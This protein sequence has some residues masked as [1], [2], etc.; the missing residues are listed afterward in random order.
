MEYPSQEEDF[1]NI[2]PLR[3]PQNIPLNLKKKLTKPFQHY[4]IHLS[5]FLNELGTNGIIKRFQSIIR[6]LPL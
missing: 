1:L 3:Q 5:Y 2:V 4:I 6:R